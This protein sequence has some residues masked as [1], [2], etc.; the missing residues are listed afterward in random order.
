MPRV[1]AT[2]YV[3][4]AITAEQAAEK[5]YAQGAGCRYGLKSPRENLERSPECGGSP[6]LQQRGATLQR[7]GKELDFDDAL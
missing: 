4:L 6:L 3:F 7:C 2:A 1:T 5:L